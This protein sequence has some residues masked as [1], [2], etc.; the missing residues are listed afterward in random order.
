M[1]KHLF[2][3]VAQIRELKSVKR[4]LAT[5][6]MEGFHVRLHFPR[7]LFVTK[8]VVLKKTNS[9]STADN[10]GYTNL[11]TLKVVKWGGGTHLRFLT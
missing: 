9:A 6:N 8:R 10:I 11:F 4:S 2:Q 5:R 7:L 3:S 1:M